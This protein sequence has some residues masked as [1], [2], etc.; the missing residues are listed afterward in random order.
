MKQTFEVENVKC[1]GC[2]NTLIS[3]LKEEFGEVSVDLDVHPRKITLDLENEKKDSLKLKL[4][5]LGYPLSSDELSGLQKATT[6]AKSFVSCA[7][8]KVNVATGK[9]E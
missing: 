3:S 6:T 9:T 1:G 4:R 8:G 5:A 7:I 2:A